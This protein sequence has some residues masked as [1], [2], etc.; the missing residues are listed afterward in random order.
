MKESHWIKLNQSKINWNYHSHISQVDDWLYGWP[1]ENESQ[2][3]NGIFPIHPESFSVFWA[4]ESVLVWVPQFHTVQHVCVHL[5]NFADPQRTQILWFRDKNWFLI[6]R[7]EIVSYFW[8]ERSGELIWLIQPLICIEDGWF[9]WDVG[10]SSSI[11]S[12]SKVISK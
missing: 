10:L 2:G 5:S 6:T 11:F 9:L 8:E 4:E 3:M 12:V 7:T 1:P